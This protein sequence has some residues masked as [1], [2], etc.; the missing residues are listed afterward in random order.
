MLPWRGAKAHW[1]G[2]ADV[3]LADRF[4]ETLEA[5]CRAIEAARQEGPVVWGGDFNLAL[6]G[7]EHAGVTANRPDLLKAFAELGLEARTAD[8]PHRIPAIRTID[9]IAVP[10]SWTTEPA[11]QDPGLSDHALYRVQVTRR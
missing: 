10:S 8:L 11:V 2:D 6:E 3:P 4:R 5:H 1:P 9:H 7:P